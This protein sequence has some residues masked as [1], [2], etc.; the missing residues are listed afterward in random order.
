MFIKAMLAVIVLLVITGHPIIAIL[1]ATASY[2]IFVQRRI[3]ELKQMC[4]NSMHQIFA[5]TESRYG[6]ISQ[7]NNKLKG[8]AEYESGTLEAI[9]TARGGKITAEELVRRDE[10]L[11]RS[12][13]VV[14][15]LAESYPV[16]K[17][18]GL[19]ATFIEKADHYENLVRKSRMVFNDTVT[20]YN[21]FVQQFPNNLVARSLGAKEM[22]KLYLSGEES[23]R[24]Y[25]DE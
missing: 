1:F 20:R 14:N 10:A 2:L 12:L 7:I 16:L 25:P 9:I 22:N 3:V 17:A 6:L 4:E 5:Q 21:I 13:G 19:H 23:R 24:D 11:H 18:S 15:A 8:Y